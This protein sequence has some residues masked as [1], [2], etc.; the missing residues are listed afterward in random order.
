MARPR[1][2]RVGLVV[3]GLLLLAG[4]LVGGR[5]LDRAGLETQIG[6][7]FQEN[8]YDP[9]AFGP[10]RWLPDGSAYSTVEPSGGGGSDIVRYDAATGERRVLDRRRRAW[11]RRAPERARRSPTTNGRTTAGG[12]WSS[13]T[14][15]RC[16]GRTPAATTGCSSS[17]RGTVDAAGRRGAGLVADVRQVLARRDARRLR[18]GPTTSTSSG[19]AT[20]GSR[21]SPRAARRPSST[22]RPTGSTRR[23]STSATASAG[24][25]TAG[26]SPTGSSTPRASACSRCINNTDALYPVVTRIPYPKAGTTNSV[27]AGRRRRRRGRRHD[28]DADARRSP[29]QLPRAARMAGRRHRSPSS[30]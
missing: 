7:I 18:A 23:S 24:A 25:P 8:A 3:T 2:G 26:A 22:A 14:P 9:P 28:L 6:R 15:A 30:S 20:A 1:S 13:P 17:A 10:A 11:C 16:G 19:S 5:A 29:R 12:C 4:P 21:G 27:G